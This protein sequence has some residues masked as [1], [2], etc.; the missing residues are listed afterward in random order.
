MSEAA[1]RDGS[2]AGATD[3]REATRRDIAERAAAIR[4]AQLERAR[5]RLEAR[6]ALTAER[7]RV[8]DELADRLVEEL[9]EAPER[10][11]READDPADAERVR[12]LFDAEE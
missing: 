8:L 7:A 10:A 3:E 11:V 1:S 5:S 6:D 9:L 12:A 4:D 2:D